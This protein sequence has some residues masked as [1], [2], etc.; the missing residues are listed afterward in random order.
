M[1]NENYWKID[2]K[3]HNIILITKKISYQGFLK[4]RNRWQYYTRMNVLQPTKKFENFF[5]IFDSL[6][7]YLFNSRIKIADA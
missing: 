3:R 7:F 1:E 6:T 2:L 5:V 4:I